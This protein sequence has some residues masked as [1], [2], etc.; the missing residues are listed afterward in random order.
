MDNII[1][2]EELNSLFKN[3]YRPASNSIIKPVKKR[4]RPKKKIEEDIEQAKSNA[5]EAL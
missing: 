5:L 3:T 4:G 1:S 2:T